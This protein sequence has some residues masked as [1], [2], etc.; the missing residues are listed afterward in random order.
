MNYLISL[1]KPLP[2]ARYVVYYSYQYTDGAQFYEAVDIELARHHQTIL[3]YEMNGERLS[4]PHRA[5]L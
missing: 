2:H 5:P 4:V 3:A 1:C